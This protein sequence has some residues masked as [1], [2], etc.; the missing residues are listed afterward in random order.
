MNKKPSFG[1]ALAYISAINDV[2][3]E[4]Y[5]EFLRLMNDYRAERIDPGGVKAKVSE[6]FKGS[7]NKHLILG[8]NNFMPT[9]YLIKLPR[10]LDDQQRQDALAFVTQVK[11][12]FKDNKEKYNKFLQVIQN[13]KDQKINTSSYIE[14]GIKLFKGHPHL[15]LGFS[16]FL[17]DGCKLTLPLDYDHQQGYQ[18]AIEDEFLNQ[19]KL[20]F[21]NNMEKYF[22]FLQVIADHKAQGIDIRGVAAIVKEL[23]KGHRNLILGFNV[24]LPKKYQITLSSEF[25]NTG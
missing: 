19:V 15:L 22:E 5:S 11:V 1:D 7:D 10:I 18:L 21:Q 4:K 14:I 2:S 25:H 12:V 20:V 17:P 9:E 8:I 23:F 16:N 3:R 6:L 13:F 24:F